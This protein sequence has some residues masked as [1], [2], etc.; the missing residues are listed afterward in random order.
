MMG[1]MTAAFAPPGPGQWALD[2]SHFAGGTTPICQW[3]MEESMARG[4]RRVFAEIGVPADTLQARF[5]NG[6]M[7]TRLRPLLRPDHAAT[8]LPPEPIL[9]VVTHL[10]PAFRRRAKAAAT[11]L[12]SR[13]WV[14]VAQR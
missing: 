9:R 7:Y 1:A 4:M 14:D 5:V 13:P 10:H 6:F 3:L 8:K 11:A 2:R 12:R